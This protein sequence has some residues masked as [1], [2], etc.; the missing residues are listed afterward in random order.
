LPQVT[1]RGRPQ[2]VQ[3]QVAWVAGHP[4]DPLQQPRRR[5]AG[6]TFW[7][8]KAQQTRDSSHKSPGT[9]P[10][11]SARRSAYIVCRRLGTRT[12]S[13]LNVNRPRSRTY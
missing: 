10:R 9:R 7:R 13:P 5:L 3:H 1:L 11:G 12:A 2:A 4:H 6:V 8:W